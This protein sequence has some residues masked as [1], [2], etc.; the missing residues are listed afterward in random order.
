MDQLSKYTDQAYALM[1]IVA[2]FMF[3]FHGAQKILGILS[4]FQPAMGSQLWFGGVIELI[5]GLLVLVG[6]QTRWAAFLAS[7][8]MAVAYFQFHWKFQLGPNFFPAINKGELAVLYCFVF[9]CIACRGGA[10]W[11]LDKK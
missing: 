10:V 6:L 3:S 7:G 2:G 4:D 5:C 11:C 8:E 1:R 9:L